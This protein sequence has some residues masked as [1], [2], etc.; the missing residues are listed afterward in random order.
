MPR[1]DQRSGRMMVA[2]MMVVVLLAMG[3]AGFAIFLQMQERDQRVA[4]ENQLALI[5]QERDDL[6]IQ[7]ASLES[8]KNQL[9][10]QLETTRQDL[11]QAKQELTLALGEKET[12]QKSYKDLEAQKGESAA[13]KKTMEQMAAEMADVRREREQL[14]AQVKRLEM[15]QAQL[16]DQLA[17]VEAVKSSLET[18]LA[19]MKHLPTVELGRVMVSSEQDLPRTKVARPNPEIKT[20]TIVR[21]SGLADHAEP[22]ATKG[23]VLVI[24]REYDFIVMDIGKNHGLSIGQKFQVVRGDDVLG[25]VKVEKVYDDLSAAAVL[26]D[27]DISYIREGDSVVAL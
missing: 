7:L 4:M 26:S 14:A 25:T 6:K 10:S 27:T 1:V 12:L 8:S 5:R 16:E 24:N 19:E 11:T 9:Q 23:Q 20:S 2:L 15:E 18:Q 13:L 22:S 17:D 3:I 21:N